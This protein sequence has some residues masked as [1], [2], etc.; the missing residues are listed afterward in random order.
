MADDHLQ[1]KQEALVQDIPE[2]S[3]SSS[4]PLAVTKEADM[5]AKEPSPSAGSGTGPAGAG[6]ANGGRGIAT[7]RRIASPTGRSDVPP[8][9]SVAGD[10][11]PTSIVGEMET[12]ADAGATTAEES[13]PLNVT[14][15]LSYLDSVKQQF[16]ENPEVYNRFLDIMK[17]FKGQL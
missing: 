12:D 13:R 6:P 4:N 1:P 2:A 11:P 15:A 10:V 5:A 3:S 7:P 9:S 8:S 17:D 14:D 16:Q